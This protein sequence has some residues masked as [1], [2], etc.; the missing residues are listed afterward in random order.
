MKNILNSDVKKKCIIFI[1][2]IIAGLWILLI[3]AKT[4]II[5]ETNDDRYISEILSGTLTGSP[6][7]HTTHVNYLL[8]LP[9]MLLYR[10]TRSV[11]WYG[12]MLVLCQIF[13]YTVLCYLFL[14]KWG[15]F[16][17][18][19]YFGILFSGFYMTGLLQYTST[20]A[21]LAATGYACFYLIDDSRKS[22]GVFFVSEMLA[23]FIRR[24]AMLMI[25]PLGMLTLL[26]LMLSDKMTFISK[27]NDKTEKSRFDSKKYFSRSFLT[28][29]I[30][31]CM[32]PV[33]SLLLA[34]V[35][36]ILG[37][38]IGYHSADWKEYLRF[39]VAREEMFDY[40][41]T[42]DYASAKRI[43]DRYQVSEAQY[44]SF[45]N[46]TILEENLSADCLCEL[47]D[48]AKEQYVAERGTSDLVHIKNCVVS[49]IRGYL[50]DEYWQISRITV[51]LWVLLVL[52]IL[53]FRKFT[54]LFPA[55]GLFIGRTITWTYLLYRGR[56][57][58]RVV[59]PMYVC[60][61]ILL[62]MM[63]G[64]ILFYD[65]AATLSS[66]SDS[67]FSKKIARQSF[68][69]AHMP[70]SMRLSVIKA[71]MILLCILLFLFV[72]L[73]SGMMQY[74]YVKEQNQAQ[75][76]FVQSFPELQEY[77]LS[78][79]E[80]HYLIEAQS[81]GYYYGG[82]ISPAMYQPRNSLV[83]GC[84]YF[85]S[86]RMKDTLNRYIGECQKTDSQPGK[87]PLYFIVIDGEKD[88]V[89]PILAY[90]SEYTG[91]P[92]TLVDQFTVSHGGT[93]LVYY[94]Q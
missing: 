64:S 43:L 57:L 46:F 76:V 91:H 85:P 40:Y 18:L 13:C 30:R 69:Q 54:F 24:Q 89:A 48:L 84:W 83:S 70:T 14:K 82:A 86:P 8:C 4:G 9:L 77:C 11:A 36:G 32:I 16:S 31:Q 10:I 62:I 87:T 65:R 59:M 92:G 78:H 27:V 73:K 71:T 68:I 20:A 33:I 52:S 75:S 41:G 72:S 93:Y 6:E 56:V 38:Y 7:A 3:Y 23:F 49:S 53:C 63:L 88:R 21:L 94:Y 22:L 45:C 44:L 1:S 35:I 61:I 55:I 51:V 50:S 17:L 90:L 66:D 42:P 81:L 60:E 47:A 74:R 34:L 15:T 29:Y 26:G 28:D 80:N 39:N 58:A 37:K 79:P 5:F 2:L 12:W 25:Q 67:S 19:L